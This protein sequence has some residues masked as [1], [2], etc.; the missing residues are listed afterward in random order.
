[1]EYSTNLSVLY[2]VQ[3]CIAISDSRIFAHE[4]RQRSARETGT[5]ESHSGG[6]ASCNIAGYNALAIAQFPCLLSNTNIVSGNCGRFACIWIGNRWFQLGKL[7][8]IQ[9]MYQFS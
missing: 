7:P 2:C 6:Y 1:M 5:L 8:K 3:T 9:L 4:Y